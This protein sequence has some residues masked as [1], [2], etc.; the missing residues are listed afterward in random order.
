MR[1]RRDM[2]GD[3]FEV[4]AHGFAVVTGHDDAGALAF[5]GADRTKNPGRGPPLIFRRTRPGSA[6]CPAPGKLGTSIYLLI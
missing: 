3:L 5:G 1:P 6:L 2:E 4:Q